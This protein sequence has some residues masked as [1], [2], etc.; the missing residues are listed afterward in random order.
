MSTAAGHIVVAHYCLPG[1]ARTGYVLWGALLIGCPFAM[2]LPR[3]A[4]LIENTV[5]GRFLNSFTLFSISHIAMWFIFYVALILHPY[6]GTP[7]Q[8]KNNRSTTWVR[9]CFS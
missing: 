4:K 7:S 3:K 1:P 5:L 8:H 6:P 2:W 9:P